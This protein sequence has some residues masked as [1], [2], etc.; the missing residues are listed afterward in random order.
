MV[1]PVN[2]MSILHKKYAKQEAFEQFW[3]VV[4][5]KEII[6]INA[7]T[8]KKLNESYTFKV[9]WA[10]KCPNPL[11]VSADR[12]HHLSYP[13]EPRP[14]ILF[15]YSTTSGHVIMLSLWPWS[16]KTHQRF[17]SCP[18]IAIHDRQAISRRRLRAP[19]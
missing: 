2:K 15:H 8:L 13:P 5:Q 1:F 9:S 7:G 16:I 14:H 19:V 6:A 12:C 11:C 4:S 10:L 17:F 18:L 3:F